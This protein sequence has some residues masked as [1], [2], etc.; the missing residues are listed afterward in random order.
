M[1]MSKKVR[2]IGLFAAALLVF[3]FASE[4]NPVLYGTAKVKGSPSAGPNYEYG[5]SVCIDVEIDAQ[6]KIIKVSDDEKNTDAS[7]EADVTGNA[8]TNKVYWKKFL[9]AKGFDKYKN[10][11]LKDVKKI[12]VGIPGKAG[13]DVVGGATAS[14]LAVKMAVLQ[15]LTLDASIKELKSYKNPDNYKKGEQKKLEKIVTEGKTLLESLETYEEIEKALE[16]LK[17]K[18]DA[19]KT[20]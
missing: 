18:L 11:T 8:G 19:L 15:A 20:K 5:Y 4:P 12:N 3:A 14:S 1:K 13:P 7:I 6:G 10:K 9:E 16:E 2:A 17:Q